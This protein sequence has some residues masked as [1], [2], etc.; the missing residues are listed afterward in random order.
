MSVNDDAVGDA[1]PGTEDNIGGLAGGSG[2]GEQLGHCVWNL[3]V[4]VVHD[5]L[6]RSDDG[7]GFVPKEP[8]G[9]DVRLE[10]FGFERGERL[11]RRVLL[12]DDGS[13]HVDA[14]V[15]ALRGEY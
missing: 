14:Y 2:D 3:A 4:E 12:E 7:F 6:R 9:A 15:G 10:L 13:D 11:W 1:E 8:G 5:F